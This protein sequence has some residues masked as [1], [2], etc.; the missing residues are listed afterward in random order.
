MKINIK[1]VENM[2][3]IRKHQTIVV[4]T[5][6]EREELVNRFLGKPNKPP[7]KRNED[8][9]RGRTESRKG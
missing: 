1:G 6:K 7:D 3:G 2:P 8:N 5:A 9:S 4:K